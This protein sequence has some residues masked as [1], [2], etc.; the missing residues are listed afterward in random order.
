MEE[1]FKEKRK[2][3]RF[4]NPNISLRSKDVAKKT[5]NDVTEA[6][7]VNMSY[8]GVSILSNVEL[9][10]GAV[11]EIDIAVPFTPRPSHLEGEVIWSK[12]KKAE[13]GSQM[14]TSGIKLHIG[15]N[16]QTTYLMYI[17]ELMEQHIKKLEHEQGLDKSPPPL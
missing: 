10:P 11:I 9:K 6:V 13:D 5:L 8:E 1:S 14:Y 4:D 12:P 7:A 15:K 2:H 16:D 3:V 17:C